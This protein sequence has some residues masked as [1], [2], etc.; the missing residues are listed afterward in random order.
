MVYDFEM[1][2]T[3]PMMLPGPSRV[4]RDTPAFASGN[5]LVQVHGSRADV[6]GRHRAS[7]RGR[8]GDAGAQAG[9]AGGLGPHRRVEGGRGGARRPSRLRDGGDAGHL[10]GQDG[11]VARVLG[12]THPRRRKV[13]H[14]ARAGGRRVSADTTQPESRLSHVRRRAVQ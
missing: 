2:I 1:S 14:R 12:R 13:D 5:A 8:P 9:G 11:L 10:L 6:H 7:R 3:N 4:E